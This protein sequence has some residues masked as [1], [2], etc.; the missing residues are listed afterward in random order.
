ML[1]KLLEHKCL[2]W[3]RMTH[4]VTSNTSYGQ[5]KGRESNCQFDSQPLKVRNWPDFLVCKWRATYRC[6]AIDKGYKFA[7]NIISIEGLHKKL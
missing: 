7:S 1:G 2:K 5:K 6:K 4:L 3:A